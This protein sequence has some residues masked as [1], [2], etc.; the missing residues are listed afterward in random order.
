[1]RLVFLAAMVALCVPTLAEEKCRIV[2]IY[3]QFGSDNSTSGNCDKKGGGFNF[4]AGAGMFESLTVSL[5]PA[6]GKIVTHGKS[7]FAYKPASGFRGPDKF[8]VRMCGSSP[9][10]RGCSNLTYSLTVE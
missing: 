1:M 6:H 8:S 2:P 4:G 7:T 10:S 3:F 9:T 5:E